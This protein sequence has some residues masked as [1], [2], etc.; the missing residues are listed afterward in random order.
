M[1]I[2]H[3]I[4]Q[5][6]GGG[7]ERQLSYLAP[8]M[9]RAGHEVH[10]AYLRDGPEI[11][12]FPGVILHQLKVSGNHDPKLFLKI[13]QLIRNINPDVVHSWILMMDIMAGCIVKVS[14]ANWVLREPTTMDVYRVL[15][16]KQR[17]RSLLARQASRIICNSQGGR[18]Y[19]LS[20]DIPD[21]RV[22]VIPNAIP[23]DLIEK[24]LPHEF[25]IADNN[26]IR[27]CYAGRLVQSKRAD[28]IIEAMASLKGSIDA[29]LL[30]AG[31]GPARADLL[32]LV[33]HYKLE[34]KITFAGYLRSNDL[35]AHMKTSDVFISLSEY[36]GIPN[37]VCE[38]IA[39]HLPL[40][41]SDIPAHRSFLDEDSAV[42]VSPGSM[43]EIISGILDVLNDKRKAEKRALRAKEIVAG[44]SPS[45]IAHQY[46][47]VYDG[48]GRI[49]VPWG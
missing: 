26:Q 13:L 43:D 2:L 3:L 25:S 38:A 40:V 37:C 20:Q 29:R 8:E 6:S 42:F 22:S 24:V 46:V 41:L 10:V 19:W 23:F 11:I 7:A 35:W 32:H 48:K 17:M 5:L 27:L 28:I 1:R 34:D 14:N 47:A 49:S 36:E 12:A 30:I 18:S 44:W 45:S 31:D 21:R 9:V 15:N 39:C 4:A 16:F 33:E